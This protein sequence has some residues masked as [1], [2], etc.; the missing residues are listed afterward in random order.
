[1]MKN[2]LEM[3]DVL[4]EQIIKDNTFYA[5]IINDGSAEFA[6]CLALRKKYSANTIRSYIS[7]YS[8]VKEKYEKGEYSNGNGASSAYRTFVGRYIKKS[9]L[10]LLIEDLVCMVE[11]D[12]TYVSKEERERY[13]KVSKETFAEYLNFILSRE[14]GMVEITKENIELYLHSLDDTVKQQEAIYVIDLYVKGKGLNYINLD[15]KK[16]FNERNLTNKSEVEI[17]KDKL[18]KAERKL[19]EYENN[20]EKRVDEMLEQK[21]K[22]Y[23]KK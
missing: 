2:Q 20:F 11:W 14:E 5:K 7:S 15:L 4:E 19:F 12:K 3:E 18:E 16:W 1:M 9:D 13:I 8:T 22:V 23:L 10:D 6:I 21:L 17:L